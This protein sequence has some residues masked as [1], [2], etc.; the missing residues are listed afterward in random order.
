MAT[1]TI[2]LG[3]S[4]MSH[5]AHLLLGKLQLAGIDAKVI[6][7]AGATYSDPRIFKALLDMV[8]GGILT[9]FNNLVF[10]VVLNGNF[11]FPC[12][13]FRDGAKIHAHKSRSP[14]T[15]QQNYD[16]FL[17]LT[18]KIRGI[19]EGKTVSFIYLSSPPRLYRSVCCSLGIKYGFIF[20][21]IARVEKFILAKIKC[22]EMRD[23][24]LIKQEMLIFNYFLKHKTDLS[25]FLNIETSKFDC[26]LR[27]TIKGYNCLA[28]L[29]FSTRNRFYAIDNIHL[30]R[31]GLLFLGEAY[32]ILLEHIFDLLH[33]QKFVVPFEKLTDAS[34]L[35]QTT[36]I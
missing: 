4:I 25:K 31:Q 28:E 20:R 9:G 33:S 1:M 17:D 14:A 32:F 36:T 7:Y 24:Y 21:D 15:P 10:I 5:V 26:K 11:L 6:A 12:K 13:K 2:Y 3:A 22:G 8:Q 19:C 16:A 18:I 30:S 35:T 29:Y 34:L 27:N 23:T